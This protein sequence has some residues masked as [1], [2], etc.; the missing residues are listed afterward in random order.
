[1]TNRLQVAIIDYSAGAN[2]GRVVDYVQLG[3][4]DSSQDVNSDLLANDPYHFWDNIYTNGVLLGVLNQIQVSMDGV[5]IYGQGPTGNAGWTDSA[6]PGGPANDVSPAAQQA[7]FRGFFASDGHYNYPNQQPPTYYNTQSA[8]QAPYTPSTFVTRYTSWQANDPLV[9]YLASD[10]APVSARETTIDWP[11]SI[12]G[13]LGV[14]NSRYQ[15]WGKSPPT[16]VNALDQDQNSVNLAFKD[17]LVRESDS[18]DFPAGKLPTAGWLGRV[19]RGTPWQTVYLKATNILAWANNAGQNG[20]NTWKTWTGDI[21]LFD[22]ANAAPVEDHL[23]FDLFTTAFNDNAT[24]GQLSVNVS[25]NSLAAWSAVFSGIVTLSNNLP[26]SGNQSVVSPLRAQR[27]VPSSLYLAPSYSYTNIINPAGGSGMNSALGQIVAGIDRTRATF[28]NADGLVGVFEHKGDLLAVPELT[29][30]SPFLNTSAA[31]QGN[32]ISDEMYEWLPQQA[33]SLVRVG[34]PRYVIYSY[35]QA[36]KPAPNGTYLGSATLANGQPAFG[37]VTN[38]QV[39]SETATRAVV[40]L[41]TVRTNANDAIIVTPPR[42]VIESFN[43]LPP[44]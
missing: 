16:Y 10:L 6:I 35:G 36:L 31:Q 18:W 37:M 44:D 14:V 27:A 38:Y 40:R 22:A 34:A 17:P 13:S 12:V 43:V 19:H 15:P 26:N 3:G 8:M 32:G 2:Y 20:F 9:H 11:P 4:M 1:M 41:D 25:S 21:N 24:R 39:M 28:T 5:N 23:L 33:M 7:F 30:R 42:A 29:E